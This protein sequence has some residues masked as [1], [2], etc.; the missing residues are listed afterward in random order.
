MSAPDPAAATHDAISM[1][2]ADYFQRRR[3][4]TWSDADQAELDAWLAEAASHRVAYLRVEGIVARTDQL[5]ALRPPGPKSSQT[6]R[7]GNGTILR[8]RFVLPLLAAAS[9]AAVA[10]TAIPYVNSLLQPPDRVFATN[11]G[12]EGHLKFADG[13]ELELNTDTAVRYRMTTQERTI[14][15][16]KGEAYFR[17]A[18]NAANPFTVVAAGHRIT[19]LG[20]EFLVRETGS[21]DVVLV[22]GRAQLTSSIPAA[23]V[24]TLSPGDEAVATPVSTTITKK[25]PQQLADELSWRRGV[26]VF[27]N[28]KIADVV[29]EFNRYNETRLVIADPSI[30][31][32]KFSAELKTNDFEGFLQLAEAALKLRVDREGNDFLISRGQRDVTKKAVRAKHGE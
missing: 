4:W 8:R 20:T 21:L 2:A 30:A 24:A 17:V 1:R 6:A 28:A 15:L 5:A 18:H 3:F 25:T 27:R 26:L 23:P 14:W 12:G 22:K 10:V 29:R 16:D 9:I 31:G 19:D 32:L 7:G 11:V 13:T